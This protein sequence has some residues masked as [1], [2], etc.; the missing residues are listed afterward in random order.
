M[1]KEKGTIGG[2]RRGGKLK[3]HHQFYRWQANVV[4]GESYSLWRGLQWFE[5][6]PQ[7]LSLT[8]LVTEQT[9]QNGQPK[10]LG[11]VMLFTEWCCTFVEIVDET[12]T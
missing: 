8:A 2:R 10:K 5:T 6:P 3:K 7:R 11:D 9:A 12:F 4:W 1:A